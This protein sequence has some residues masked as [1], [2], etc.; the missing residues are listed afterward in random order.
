MFIRVLISDVS[1]NE[2]LSW[3]GCNRFV[4]CYLNMRRAGLWADAV[5]QSKVEIP[6]PPKT[7]VLML[8]ECSE[9]EAALAVSSTPTP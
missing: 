9:S 1:G 3:L 5:L 6:T 8:S 4:D 2:F 7:G